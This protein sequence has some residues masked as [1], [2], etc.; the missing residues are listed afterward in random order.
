MIGPNVFKNFALRGKS[1]PK[2]QPFSTQET[3]LGVSKRILKLGHFG[4]LKSI[5]LM[6]QKSGV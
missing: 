4:A 6:D 5:L 1:M 2:A 3:R